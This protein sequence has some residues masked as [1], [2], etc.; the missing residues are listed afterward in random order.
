MGTKD[1][2]EYKNAL[3]DIAAHPHT[4]SSPFDR[5]RC[6]E[7]CRKLSNLSDDELQTYKIKNEYAQ[8]L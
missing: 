8:L 5:V 2:R 7:W 6:M 3:L 1:P 4:L